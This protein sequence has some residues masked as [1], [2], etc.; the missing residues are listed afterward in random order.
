MIIR[1]DAAGNVHL[2]EPDDFGAF[3]VEAGG[4]AA[5]EVAGAF[6]GDAEA[7][8][9]EHLWI[10]IARLHALGA[11][12]GG[13]DWRAGCDGMIAY[14]TKKGWVDASGERVRAHL[15]SRVAP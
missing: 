11:R 8:D 10:S 13:P 3:S 5:S 4:R 7:I 1:V 14:A 12:D 9:A 6:A 15:E 2:D